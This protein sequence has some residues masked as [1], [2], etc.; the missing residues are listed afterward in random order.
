MNSS[1]PFTILGSSVSE[2][3][4]RTLAALLKSEE[5]ELLRKQ[6]HYSFWLAGNRG[7][8]SYQIFFLLHPIVI[9]FAR[10]KALSNNSLLQFARLEAVYSSLQLQTKKSEFWL[11]THRHKAF[12]SSPL[13]RA[14]EWFSPKSQ[15]EF[16]SAQVFSM[17]ACVSRMA[18]AFWAK[19]SLF[20]K[21]PAL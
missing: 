4:I 20:P 16:Y 21:P 2:L 8:L 5:Q 9:F 12:H 18:A 15:F 17:I 6:N 13:W 7:I 10:Q 14:S 1:S 11:H 19:L 3:V